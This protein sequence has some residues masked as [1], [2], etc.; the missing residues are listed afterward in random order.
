MAF[1]LIKNGI[2]VSDE[3][4][5][6][7][8]KLICGETIAMRLVKDSIIPPKEWIHD[9]NIKDKFDNTVSYYLKEN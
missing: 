6:D 9:P 5:Y 2:E 4:K 7:S 1:W 3:W 8:S